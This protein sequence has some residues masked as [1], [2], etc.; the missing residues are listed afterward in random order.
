MWCFLSVNHF[1]V[2]L[3]AHFFSVNNFSY[4]CSAGQ[5][6]SGRNNQGRRCCTPEDPCGEGEGDCDGPG[7]GGLNDGHD[8]CQGDLECGS[9]NCKQFGSFYHEKD[10]C[11]QKPSNSSTVRPP[12][13][14]FPGSDLTPPVGKKKS[15]RVRGA[16]DI[17]L[18]MHGINYVFRGKQFT[19]YNSMSTANNLVRVASKPPIDAN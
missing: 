13:V 12:P 19:P 9:N 3:A 1:Q 15:T 14:I 5:R 7:D 10:D 17:S 8:G 2:I 11:C 4:Q 6:C 16:N 18:H